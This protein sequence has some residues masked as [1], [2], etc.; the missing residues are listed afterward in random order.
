MR[1]LALC[2]V[3]SALFAAE[4]TPMPGPRPMGPPPAGQPQSI[5]IQMPQVKTLSTIRLVEVGADGPTAKG[6]AVLDALFNDGWRSTGISTV[7]PTADGLTVVAV[8]AT[9]AAPKDAP[10]P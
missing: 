9:K 1:L 5:P 8:L 4:A 3:T 2:L 10:K 7:T 6:Q